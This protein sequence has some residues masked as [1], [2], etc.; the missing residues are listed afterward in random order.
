MS[1]SAFPPIRSKILQTNL[2]RGARAMDVF[3]HAMAERGC[4]LEVVAEPGW[5]PPDSADWH[6]SAD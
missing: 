6:R 3:H 4:G 2:G 5:T 1:A